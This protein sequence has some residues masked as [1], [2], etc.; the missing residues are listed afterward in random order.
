VRRPGR[1]T[2]GALIGFLLVSIILF[3]T[4]AVLGAE[5]PIPASITASLGASIAAICIIEWLWE[6]FGG[7]PLAQQIGDFQ[8]A[9]DGA[10]AQLR[11]ATS[12]LRDLEGTGVLR[13][14]ASRGQELH[15]RVDLW[16]ELLSHAKEVDL[17]GLT[18]YREWFEH[19]RLCAGVR[20]VLSQNDGQVRIIVLDRD[21]GSSIKQRLVQPGEI[22]REGLLRGLLGGTYAELKK[23]VPEMR[24]YVQR[25]A[26]QI[27]LIREC[28][29]YAMVIRIDDYM[30]V[31]PYVASAVGEFSF[32]M[33]L[34]GRNR[35]AYDIYQRE[36]E[37]IF[38][39]G[40]PYENAN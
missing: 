34:E 38:N 29:L 5:R 23:L 25:G 1:R 15:Q 19:E 31:A 32:A 9:T 11:T 28:T 37:A 6:Q 22:D 27:R 17:M 20:N 36:L 21:Q 18:L 33:A 39:C 10:L 24:P 13:M 35:R 4:A 30:F 14:Y 16:A 7:A 40:V 26:L 3:L 12:S 8:T 2:G